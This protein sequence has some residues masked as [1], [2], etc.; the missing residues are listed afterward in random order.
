MKLAFALVLAAALATGAAA[1]P[2]KPGRASIAFANEA[3]GIN[4]W[5]VVD[6]NTVY[7]QG[8]GNKWYRADLFSPCLDLPYAETLGF[9]TN[10]GGSFDQTSAV[11]ARGHRCPLRALTLVDAPPAKTVRDRR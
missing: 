4:D 2:P 7:L 5:R 8:N 1:K 11:I 3:G 6:A 9:E 10:P